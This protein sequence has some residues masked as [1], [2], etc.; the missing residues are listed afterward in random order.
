MSF[1]NWAY[2]IW[3][4]EKEGMISKDYQVKLAVKKYKE[5]WKQSLFLGR[6]NKAAKTSEKS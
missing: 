2:N 6:E 3:K 1:E 5:V 4:K